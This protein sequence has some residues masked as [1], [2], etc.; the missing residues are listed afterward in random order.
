MGI[1][2]AGRQL[3][4]AQEDEDFR[5]VEEISWSMDSSMVEFRDRRV[6]KVGSRGHQNEE[7]GE[8]RQ[9]FDLS[10]THVAYRPS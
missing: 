4:F 9:H 7:S 1:V 2:K 10:A 5:K 3:S 6:N 8:G